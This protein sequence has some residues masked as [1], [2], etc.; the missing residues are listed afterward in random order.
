MIWSKFGSKNGE[1]EKISDSTVVV[2][3]ARTA[4][5]PNHFRCLRSVES[6][7]LEALRSPLI[8]SF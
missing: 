1:C 4:K 2:A 6:L 8:V 7:D 3:E 5:S